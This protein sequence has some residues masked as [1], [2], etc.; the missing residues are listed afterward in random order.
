MQKKWSKFLVIAICFVLLSLALVACKPDPK[1]DPIDDPTPN[2]LFREM[3]D[4]MSK[5]F[6]VNDARNF[7]IDA[8]AVASL[9]TKNTPPPPHGVEISIHS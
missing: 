5:T 4:E 8:E 1:P 9:S 3:Y 7:A 6:V 2:E